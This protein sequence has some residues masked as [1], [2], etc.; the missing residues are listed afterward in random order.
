MKGASLIM[1]MVS[2]LEN[3]DVDVRNRFVES[4]GESKFSELKPK[5]VNGSYIQRYQFLSKTIL[6]NNAG[7][8]IKSIVE[9]LGST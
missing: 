1:C 4:V 3:C 7:R 5:L 9:S 6:A 8:D 2:F